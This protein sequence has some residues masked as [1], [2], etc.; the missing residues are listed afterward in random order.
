MNR[1]AIL[2]A[3]DQKARQL[4]SG[5]SLCHWGILLHFEGECCPPATYLASLERLLAQEND[6]DTIWPGHHGFPVDK[7]YL[8][9]YH[10]CATQIVQGTATYK[11]EKG[12]RCATFGRI[13]ISVP[14][15]L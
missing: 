1:C 14:K 11:L 9:E 2:Y 4:F 10:T 3:Y 12:R 5:D 8:A 7:D 13:L 6:F 15:E